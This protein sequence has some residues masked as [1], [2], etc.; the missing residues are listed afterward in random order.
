MKTYGNLHAREL[1]G[2][3]RNPRTD[4][5][6]L[7]EIHTV[8]AIGD[9]DSL[10]AAE[11][12]AYGFKEAS[13]T[14]YFPLPALEFLQYV[15]P[16]L[17]RKEVSHILVIGISASGGS[18]VVVKAIQEIRRLYPAMKTA[19]VCGKDGAALAEAVEY[20]ESVQLEELGR[21]PGIRT[22]GASLAGLLSLACGIGEAKNRSSGLSREGIASLLE[23]GSGGVEKTIEHTLG[24]GE[25]LAALAEGPFISCIGCGPDQGTASFSGAKIVEA[26]G[27]YA[28]GQD[29]EEWN[30][31]ESF[32]YPLDSPMLVIAN[33]G[34]ALKRTASLV[35][36]GKALGH[37]LIVV[38]P[39]GLQDFDAPADRVVP[40]YGPGS[41]WLNIFTQYIPGTILAYYL[42]KRLNRAMFMS[43]RI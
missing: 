26:S 27:M 40:V 34:P 3:I 16:C 7:K 30:H 5:I 19:G 1:P 10:Y 21:T 41:P 12:A 32:A 23:S 29:P 33:P 24:M 38:G 25:E 18:P 8:Y 37:R 14:A 20:N 31:V 2:I 6:N 9:G 17:G 11:A 15:L 4:R 43:D 35:R 22:Y 36:T 13:G 42:A 39:E 28:P